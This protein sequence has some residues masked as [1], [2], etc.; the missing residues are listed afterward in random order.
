M[1]ARKHGMTLFATKPATTLGSKL[2]TILGL[3]LLLTACS[4]LP[5]SPVRL[6]A[7]TATAKPEPTQPSTIKVEVNG[8]GPRGTDHER[9]RVPGEAG[10]IRAGISARKMG[11]NYR[12]MSPKSAFLATVILCWC[13]ERICISHSISSRRRCRKRSAKWESGK[14]VEIP[15]RP[16]GPSGTELQRVLALE[17]YDNFPNILLTTVEY[18]NTGARDVTIEKSVNQKRR[19]SARLI[20]AKTQ[21]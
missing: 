11:G 14:R 5:K 3:L 8:G 10:W 21:P 19:L 16:L 4:K 15:A 9:R 13:R 6:P 1:I 12:W 20:E 18:K 7:K 17:V 2:A